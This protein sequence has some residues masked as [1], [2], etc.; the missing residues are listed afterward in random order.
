MIKTIKELLIEWW[1]ESTTTKMPIPTIYT[2]KV[3]VDGRRIH[4]KSISRS[5]IYAHYKARKRFPDAKYIR[6]VSR[7]KTYWPRLLS[8]CMMWWSNYHYKNDGTGSAV[9]FS[10]D[11]SGMFWLLFNRAFYRHNHFFS[12]LFQKKCNQIWWFEKYYLNLQLFFG[13]SPLLMVV[14]VWQGTWHNEEAFTW[15]LFLAHWNLANSNIEAR[16]RAKSRCPRWDMY[17]YLIQMW[18]R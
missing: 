10:P 13:R 4:I 12:R 3:D 16:N 11:K 5:R 2:Y 14:G 6:V 8:M 1:A 18:Y 17:I 9:F 7:I 15:R